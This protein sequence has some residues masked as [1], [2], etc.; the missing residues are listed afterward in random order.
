MRC[1]AREQAGY[2]IVPLRQRPAQHGLLCLEVAEPRLDVGHLRL[3][4]LNEAGSLDQACVQPLPLDLEL[5]QVRCDALLALLALVE[6]L[7]APLELALCFVLALG[8]K[9]QRQRQTESDQSEQR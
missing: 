9:R 6:L 3:A 1:M 4:L 7:A 8:G 5:A 2:G